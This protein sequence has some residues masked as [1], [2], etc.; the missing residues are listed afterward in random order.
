MNG[1][2][3]E[4]QVGTLHLVGG[5]TLNYVHVRCVAEVDLQTMQGRG[6]LERM[7]NA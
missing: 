4:N 3:F 6:R 2:D 1:A 5:L 7:E